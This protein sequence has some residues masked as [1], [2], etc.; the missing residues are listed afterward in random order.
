MSE[1]EQLFLESTKAYDEKDYE[2]MMS[3]VTDDYSWFSMTESGSV[4]KSKGKDQAIAGL[5][6]VFESGAYIKGEVAFLKAFGN[7]VVAYE[8]DQYHDGD[9]VVTRGTL[10]IYQ[11]KDKKLARVFS[12]P[13]E[14][15]A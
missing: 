13:V 11:Y 7:I 12:F 14:D 6:M 15:E 8:T 9:E 10:G 4:L 3:F 2:K 5:K 1:Y